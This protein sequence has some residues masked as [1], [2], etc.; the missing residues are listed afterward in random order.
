VFG[1]FLYQGQICMSTERIVLDEAI[2]DEF[3]ARFAARAQELSVGDPTQ[4][5]GCV[6]G[7]MVAKESGPR[8]PAAAPSAGQPGA[9]GLTMQAE[10]RTVAKDAIIDKL[11]E[12]LP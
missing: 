1:S 5:P 3:V 2:A 11:P 10:R 6:I 8:L 7:P 4:N 9:C 12:H